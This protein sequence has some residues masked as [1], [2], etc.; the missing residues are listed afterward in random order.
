MTRVQAT[1]EIFWTAFKALPRKEQSV[2]LSKLFS[3]NKVSE[4]LIDLA[5]WAK[6]RHEPSRPFNDY[7]RE[8][9]GA[10]AREI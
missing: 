1:A 2:F 8:R 6:R 9:K 7:L 10:K 4:D 3:D 5:I